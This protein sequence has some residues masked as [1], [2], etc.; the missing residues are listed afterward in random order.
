MVPFPDSEGYHKVGSL[1]GYDFYMQYEPLG[2]EIQLQCVSAGQEPLPYTWFV[3]M[4]T[5]F[6]NKD[7][8]Q[9]WDIF[10]EKLTTVLEG[11]DVGGTRPETDTE[12]AW[13]TIQELV[14]TFF[15]GDDKMDF[16][17]SQV[18]HSTRDVP[19]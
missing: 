16:D 13:R 11:F 5:N 1:A 14:D 18:D 8:M 2:P 4:D 17:Q 7:Y 6:G 10:I 9:Q 12:K 19:V 15:V 3:S